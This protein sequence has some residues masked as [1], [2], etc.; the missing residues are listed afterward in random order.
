MHPASTLT[1]TDIYQQNDTKDVGAIGPIHKLLFSVVWHPPYGGSGVI[2]EQ[3]IEDGEEAIGSGCVLKVTGDAYTFKFT[4]DFIEIIC[5]LPGSPQVEIW[6]IIGGGGG[7]GGKGGK[8]T[9]QGRDLYG[10][11]GGGG[12]GGAVYKQT[13]GQT[14]GGNGLTSF[15]VDQFSTGGAGGGGGNHNIQYFDGYDGNSGNF[16][17][18]SVLTTTYGTNVYNRSREPSNSTHSNAGGGSNEEP[19]LNSW[20]TS[21][22]VGGSGGELLGSWLQKGTNGTTGQGPSGG[23][24]GIGG[25]WSAPGGFSPFPLPNGGNGGD[26]GFGIGSSQGHGRNGQSGGSANVMFVRLTY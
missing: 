2:T 1:F 5:E 17:G 16:P 18:N 21:S 13:Y 26:G 10:A 4:G 3:D 9:G 15:K 7:G 23:D 22:S 6:H 19:S 20:P 14:Y 12:A 8:N 11:G 25:T 24:G